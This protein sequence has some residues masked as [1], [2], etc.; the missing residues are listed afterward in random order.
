MPVVH[1]L[2][3]LHSLLAIDI[4]EASKRQNE[5]A[6]NSLEGYLYRVRDLL[7]DDNERAPFVKCSKESERKAISE[8][9]EETFAWLSDEGEHADTSELVE[10]RGALAYVPSSSRTRRILAD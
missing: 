7:S 8:K 5:D 4:Q 3:I 10:K 9:L 2:N 6:R 1:A